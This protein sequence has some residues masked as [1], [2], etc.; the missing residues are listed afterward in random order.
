MAVAPDSSDKNFKML[1]FK[2]ASYRV[3]P[4]RL[5]AAEIPAE[6]LRS[7]KTT[8]VNFIY[9]FFAREWLRLAR[10]ARIDRRRDDPRRNIT[11]R[12]SVRIVGHAAW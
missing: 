12:R 2:P 8:S 5:N 1:R 11:M 10:I 3:V 6:A 7:G 9:Y 4:K